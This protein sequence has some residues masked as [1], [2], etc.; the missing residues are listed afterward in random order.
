MV[1]E[2]LRAEMPVGK[3]SQRAFAAHLGLQ[4]TNYNSYVNHPE[5]ISNFFVERC[6]N[7]FHQLRPYLD[8]LREIIDAEHAGEA[9]PDQTK[10]IK[11]E[12][13]VDNLRQARDRL[14]ADIDLI[15]ENAIRLAQKNNSSPAS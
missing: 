10:R 1:I 9:A 8:E 7:R 2:G 5:N 6:A 4:L 13:A 3:N 11:T 12:K 15:V 14:K